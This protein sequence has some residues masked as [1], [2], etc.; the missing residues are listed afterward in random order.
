M[1]IYEKKRFDST[2]TVENCRIFDDN[3]VFIGFLGLLVVEMKSF[4]HM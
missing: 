4:F 3:D 1:G 2:I